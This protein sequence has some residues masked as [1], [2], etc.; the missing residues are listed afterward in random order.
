MP[1]LITGRRIGEDGHPI[2]G[3]GFEYDSQGR[4][5]NLLAQRQSVILSQP[6]TGEWV[7]GL[8]SAEETGGKFERGVGVFPTGNA[9]PPE[10]YHPTYD[11]H[12]EVIQGTFIMVLDG[13]ERPI[14]VGDRVVVTRGT[15]HTFR[16][17]GD[18]VGVVVV[19]THPA[20][21]IRA[22]IGTLFG[23]AHEG[24]LGARGQP[25]FLHAMVIASEYADDSVFTSPSPAVV[26]PLARALAP[27]ARRLGH[28]ASYAHYL[29]ESFW[30]ARVEQPA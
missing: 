14:Q 15:R 16:C 10:H 18:G 1:T 22:V 25:G 6:L 7:F 19:E 5:A 30:K 24:K 29:D 23:M 26:L 3:T 8:T 13:E 4:L 21:R 17:V 9:G 12:F 11:E 27:L 28:R 2:D 20:A